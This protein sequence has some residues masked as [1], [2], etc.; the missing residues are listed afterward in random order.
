MFEILK[1]DNIDDSLYHSSD[2]RPEFEIFIGDYYV[3]EDYKNY[4]S[5]KKGTTNKSLDE[6][7]R[8]IEIDLNSCASPEYN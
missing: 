1:E 2:E 5:V 8:T 6:L 7:L 3:Q 4:Y